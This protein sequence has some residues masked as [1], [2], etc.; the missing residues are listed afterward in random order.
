M[1]HSIRDAA[2]D[3]DYA[4]T[5]NL[6]RTSK[7]Y[8]KM[9]GDKWFWIEKAKRVYGLS[10]H[11]FESLMPSIDGMNIDADRANTSYSYKYKLLEYIMDEANRG[12]VSVNYDSPGSPWDRIL[13]KRLYHLTDADLDALDEARRS[14]PPERTQTT[15]LSYLFELAGTDAFD[16]KEELFPQY[17]VDKYVIPYGMNDWFSK[18]RKILPQNIQAFLR[19]LLYDP[20]WFSRQETVIGTLA[21]TRWR[22]DISTMLDIL[23]A[24]YIGLDTH[25]ADMLFM[26]ISNKSEVKYRKDVP[27]ILNVIKRDLYKHYSLFNNTYKEYALISPYVTLLALSVKDFDTVVEAANL[28]KQDIADIVT[29]MNYII[30][31]QGNGVTA[32][33]DM[34]VRESTMEH[35]GVDTDAYK[36]QFIHFVQRRREFMDEDA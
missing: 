34:H 13:S 14:L 31:H 23:S 1:H 19:K 17:L 3:L 36:E 5:I 8:S 4:D 28:S 30:H 15:M 18:N 2:Y 32:I 26:Q 16:D 21:S 24:I 27:Q 22:G 10:A 9:C 11:E 6:C 25:P 20:N 12:Y 33:T 35:V 7:F 29:S